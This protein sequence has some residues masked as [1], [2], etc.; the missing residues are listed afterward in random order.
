MLRCRVF[1]A[2]ADCVGW[3]CDSLASSLYRVLRISAK[4]S[5]VLWGSIQGVSESS[6]VRKRLGD[7]DLPRF[8]FLWIAFLAPLLL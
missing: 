1:R 2:R 5:V 7:M 8:L 3:D 6:W 4:P